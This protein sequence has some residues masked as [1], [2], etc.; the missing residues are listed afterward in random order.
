MELAQCLGP[1]WAKT[2]PHHLIF[3]VL[4]Q[5]ILVKSWT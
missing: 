1:D 3:T 5:V 2:C 4:I